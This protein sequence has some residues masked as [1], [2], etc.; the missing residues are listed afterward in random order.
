[1]GLP[2]VGI[3]RRLPYTGAGGYSMLLADGMEVGRTLLPTSPPVR[4]RVLFLLQAAIAQNHSDTENRVS[5]SHFP[6]LAKF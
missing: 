6:T 2:V 4:H 3:D 5:S 1:M